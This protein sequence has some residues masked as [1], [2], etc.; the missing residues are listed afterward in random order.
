MEAPA[1]DSFIHPC[2]VGSS[3]RHLIG[4]LAHGLANAVSD[5]GAVASIARYTIGHTTSDQLKIANLSNGGR[6]HAKTAN[7]K[8][9][10]VV[11]MDRARKPTVDCF[12]QNLHAMQTNLA[13]SSG[14]P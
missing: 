6:M 1:G 14:G 11:Y 12:S 7:Y 3:A 13:K 2:T 8:G 10:V 5:A 9:L 4:R